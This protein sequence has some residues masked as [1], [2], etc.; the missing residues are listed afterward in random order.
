[1]N[2]AQARRLQRVGLPPGAPPAPSA[3][4]PAAPSAAP[5]AARPGPA[6]QHPAVI[7]LRRI[8]ATVEP[9]PCE[10]S[11]C[12]ELHDTTVYRLADGTELP[13][14]QLRPG[15]VFYSP[16]AL[17]RQQLEGT[18]SCPWDNCDGHH[19]ICIVPGEIDAAGRVETHHWTVTGRASNCA[20][21]DDRH[22]RCWVLHGDPER[23][24]TMHVDKEGPTCKAGAGSIAV[25]GYHG[26]LDHG[27]LRLSRL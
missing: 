18:H 23:P 24:E 13:Q 14:S 19:L 2:P 22:H 11:T 12:T 5:S 17:R 1:M 26:F 16:W 21:P 3:A 10:L 25:P 8:I 20:M 4:P 6:R 7:P 27:A 9:R 15:D